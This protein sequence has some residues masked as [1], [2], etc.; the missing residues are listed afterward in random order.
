MSSSACHGS[1]LIPPP[2][3]GCDFGVHHRTALSAS[4][5]VANNAF[6]GFLALD[7]AGAERVDASVPLDGVLMANEYYFIV[8]GSRITRYPIVPSFRGWQFPHGRIPDFWPQLD[9]TL[10]SIS[11]SSLLCAVTGYSWAVQRAH[12]VPSNERA[13]FACNGMNRYGVGAVVDIDDPAN[14]IPL[15]A[16]VHMCLDAWTFVPTP[17]I[18]GALSTTGFQGAGANPAPDSM[19][20][21]TG[22]TQQQQQQVEYA[23]HILAGADPTFS[24]LHHDARLPLWRLASSSREFLYARFALNVLMAV[25]A[26]VTAG[27][28]QRVVRF[29]VVEYDRGS[30]LVEDDLHGPALFALYGAGK[31]WSANPPKRRRGKGSGASGSKGGVGGRPKL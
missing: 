20:S 10:P 12:L 18:P 7:A 22:G 5:I 30:E 13:W 11:P 26:F 8:P 21:P 28:R 17:K 27:Q 2:A 4:Q 3:T 6:D 23:V 25:K 29:M 9:Q 16:D 1:T 15:K 19:P 14:R 24:R 31:S